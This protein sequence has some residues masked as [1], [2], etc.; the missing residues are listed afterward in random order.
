M[1]PAPAAGSRVSGSSRLLDSVDANHLRHPGHGAR[2]RQDVKLLRAA[3]QGGG[4]TTRREMLHYDAWSAPETPEHLL[5]KEMVVTVACANGW[6][7]GSEVSGTSPSG[8]Q[9]RA[10]V[11]AEKGPHKVAVEIQWSAH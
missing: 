10:D 1:R 11:L 6:T 2:G 5:L 7:A 9:W 3:S 4:S 8:E